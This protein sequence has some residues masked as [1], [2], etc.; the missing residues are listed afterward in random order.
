MMKNLFFAVERFEGDN[1]DW[2][3]GFEDFGDA[4]EAVCNMRGDESYPDACI[5][6]VD[7]SG[8]PRLIERLCNFYL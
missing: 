1:P 4:V 2:S 6:V 7:K 5:A 8:E 3:V